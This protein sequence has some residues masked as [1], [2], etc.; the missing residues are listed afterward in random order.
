LENYLIEEKN[1]IIAINEISK[2]IDFLLQDNFYYFL[3]GNCDINTLEKITALN[4]A[5]RLL[6]YCLRKR[7]TEY[8][9]IID[10]NY[11]DNFTY[12]EMI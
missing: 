8:Y 10:K 3:K 1:Y 11:V 9:K 12:D 5:V 7:R 2:E 6:T 4:T